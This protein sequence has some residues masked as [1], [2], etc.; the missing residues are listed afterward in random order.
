M[1]R[2]ADGIPSGKQWRMVLEAELQAAG[3]V[4][5]LWSENAARSAEVRK[6]YLSAIDLG[7]DVAPVLLDSTPLPAELAPNMWVDL[8]GVW[9]HPQPPT[10]PRPAPV[11]DLG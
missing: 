1:F 9:P 8:R 11:V 4:L 6:E 7:K 2:D 5:V 3:C 10:A